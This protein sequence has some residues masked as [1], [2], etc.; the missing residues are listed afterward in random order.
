MDAQELVERFEAFDD[1]SDRYR[2]VIDLG[3][4]LPDLDDAHKVDANK[5]LGCQSQVWVVVREATNERVVFDGDSDSSIVKGLIAVLLVLYSGR[6]PA[7]IV[8]IDA[9]PY[10]EQLGLAGHLSPSR[11]NGFYA[12]VARIKRLAAER[13]TG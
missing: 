12:M 8:A 1:W 7:D 3:R 10:F 5:V 4:Q 9:K 11:A 13:A 6:S 2:Y